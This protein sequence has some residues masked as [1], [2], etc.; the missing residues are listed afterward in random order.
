M[1]IHERASTL[2]AVLF[3]FAGNATGELVD[4]WLRAETISFG[5]SL[6]VIVI[7]I[8]WFGPLQLRGPGTAARASA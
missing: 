8:V 5:I 3:H 7:V 2:S 1:T 6:V 4:L